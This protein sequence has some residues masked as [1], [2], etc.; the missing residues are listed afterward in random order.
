MTPTATLVAPLPFTPSDF[1]L[2]THA[3]NNHSGHQTDAALVV[4]SN[5][6][7]RR[8]TAL[9]ASFLALRLDAV[10]R[11][12]SYSY[13]ELFFLALEQAETRYSFCGYTIGAIGSDV[14]V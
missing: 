2:E 3:Y 8:A 4:W 13:K 12:P 9:I 10:P 7:Q 11:P 6:M 14:C 5:H 1:L